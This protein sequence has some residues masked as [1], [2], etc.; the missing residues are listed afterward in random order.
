[1]AWSDGSN[2]GM[3]YCGFNV[4]RIAVHITNKVGNTPMINVLYIITGILLVG[5][6]LYGLRQ[7]VKRFDK[8]DFVI[9]GDTTI[10]SE[11]DFPDDLICV[12]LSDGAT[13]VSPSR[14]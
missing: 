10:P 6:C 4:G 2:A 5:G 8:A 12:K 9:P 14:E 11:E 7:L 3:E 1:M 13:W